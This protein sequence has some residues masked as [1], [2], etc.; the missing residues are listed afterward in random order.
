MHR[1]MG[2][3]KIA[4]LGNRS[5]LKQF[6][7]LTKAG[8]YLQLPTQPNFFDHFQTYTTLCYGHSELSREEKSK[9]EFEEKKV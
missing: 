7:R 4:I 5:S 3:K 6:Y 8:T 2:V 1:A 9:F